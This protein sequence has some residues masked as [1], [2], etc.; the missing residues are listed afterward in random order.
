MNTFV[1]YNLQR[2]IKSVEE[3]L[4]GKEGGAAND[5]ANFCIGEDFNWLREEIESDF[6]YMPENLI[7]YIGSHFA[8]HKEAVDIAHSYEVS[9]IIDNAKRMLLEQIEQVESEVGTH[10]IYDHIVNEIE[11][12]F[13]GK[14]SL[15]NLADMLIEKNIVD[16]QE[17]L[18]SLESYKKAKAYYD[19][20]YPV[21]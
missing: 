5:Y 13:N 15:S 8:E 20:K 1:E 12:R 2:L 14:N 4:W 18:E 10:K 17:E 6:D 9:K 16:S 19:N 11:N 7:E 21:L 3:R